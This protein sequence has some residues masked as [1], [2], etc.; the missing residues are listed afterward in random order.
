MTVHKKP[1][2]RK[3]FL[4]P[5]GAE[6]KTIKNWHRKESMTKRNDALFWFIVIETGNSL[7]GLIIVKV[8]NQLFQIQT[9]NSNYFI[10]N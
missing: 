4:T 2:Q 6:K 7:L 3:D 1:F 10:Q 8:R 5:N 9:R